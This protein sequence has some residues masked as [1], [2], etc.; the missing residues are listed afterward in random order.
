MSNPRET[1]LR[2]MNLP[3]SRFDGVVRTVDGMY[4]A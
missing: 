1:I 3:A 4:I 2:L